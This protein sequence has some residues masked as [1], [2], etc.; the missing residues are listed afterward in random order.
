[1]HS[2]YDDVRSAACLLDSRRDQLPAGHLDYV[3]SAGRREWLGRPFNRLVYDDAWICWASTTKQVAYALI[4]CHHSIVPYYSIYRSRSIIHW[5]GYIFFN[6]IMSMSLPLIMCSRLGATARGAT[7]TT[8]HMEDRVHWTSQNNPMQ[9]TPFSSEL[10]RSCWQCH[11]PYYDSTLLPANVIWDEKVRSVYLTIKKIK[12]NIMVAVNEAILRIGER[13]HVAR[14]ISKR[15]MMETRHFPRAIRDEKSW[16]ETLGGPG[17]VH[18]YIIFVAGFW[19]RNQDDDGRPERI[20]A[21]EGDELVFY[22][23]YRAISLSLVLR[24]L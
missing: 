3:L 21:Q 1:M 15:E 18:Q 11:D 23:L 12:L 24:D 6:Q 13:T 4:C 9:R 5:I 17:H 16:P 8:G 22:Y 20:L 14:N 7:A 2:W 19:R 10:L